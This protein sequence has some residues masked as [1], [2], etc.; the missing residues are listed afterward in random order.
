[1][2]KGLNLLGQSLRA[3]GA[4]VFFYIIGG[5]MT[6]AMEECVAAGLRGIDVRDERAA[7]FAA[8]A[9]SR[10]TQKP[11]IVLSAAGPGTTNI[12]TGIA[13]AYAD[14]APVI[15]IGGS[16]PMYQ[17]DMGAFQET[18]QVSLMSPITKWAFQVQSVDRMPEAILRA[19][20]VAMSGRPGPVYL[21]LPGDVLYAETDRTVQPFY[22]ATEEWQPRS[23]ADA[24]LVE[25]ALDL[26]ASA[27]R[28]IVIA[29]SGVIWS[30]ASA[31]LQRFVEASGIPVYTTPMA[32]GV[33][34]DDH[35]LCRPAARTVAFQEADC[36][37][38]IGTRINY[39][40]GWLRPP[41]VAAGAKIIEINVQAEDLSHH[42]V[43]DV[44]I[45]AD[46]RLALE[47]LTA[48]V[49]RR[50][51]PSY[52]K[53]V[54]HLT[55]SHNASR[56]KML[57]SGTSDETPIH[58]LRLCTELDRA[59]PRDAIVVVDGHEILGFSRRAVATYLP[60]HNLNPGFY[61]TMGV[62]V[63]FGLGAKVAAPDKT[64]VVL[65][66]DGAFGYHA[67]ELDTAV[68]H[69]LGIVFVISNNGGWTGKRGDGRP[70]RD[71][72]LTAFERIVDVFGCWGTKV[73]EP[74]AIGPAIAEALAYA[75]REHKPAVVNVIVS[76][77]QAGGRSFIE[78]RPGT[79]TAY[80]PV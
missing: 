50:R 27:E 24:P 18:D 80:D 42:R 20:Q 10:V 11:G 39:I 46:A 44:A 8:I 40:L 43:A 6:Q 52:A 34:P 73:C 35:P 31:E 17:R 64:V 7:A 51:K 78:L 28:P 9:Y 14:G 65:T 56:T 58:P 23:A 22:T 48:A 5:P 37:L 77:A 2:Q 38:V 76:T 15:A 57:A 63:P 75:Q 55:D 79:V 16:S 54:E 66:G 53:W 60:S 21:D 61:G 59:L 49:A 67:M 74:Q 71:L 33:V 29:G 69:G 1:M 4:E 36:I 19:F 30:R 45:L 68:R 41:V 26:L 72:G 3:C 47:Q 62:G 25:R 70:G 32:R 12:M 13:H